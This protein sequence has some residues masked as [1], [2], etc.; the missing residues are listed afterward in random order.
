[1]ETLPSTIHITQDEHDD[2]GRMIRQCEEDVVVSKC[3]GS[4]QSKVQPSVNTLS[5]FYKDC[6]CCRET[7]LRQREV[8]LTRCYD[9]D[10]LQL[11]GPRSAMK[12]SLREPADC[13]CY[14]CG[15]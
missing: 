11:A 1:C 5:G 7:S 4:C 3:E 10:G 15:D 12:V 13:T 9:A 14:K 6:R 2:S 8:V